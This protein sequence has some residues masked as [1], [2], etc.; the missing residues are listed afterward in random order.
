MA[1]N[2]SA[3]QVQAILMQAVCN[4]RCTVLN[5]GGFHDEPPCAMLVTFVQ[6]E[7]PS[8]TRSEE[9]IS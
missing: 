5:N 8:L 4:T 3:N 9:K 6:G 7:V 1:G 2:G